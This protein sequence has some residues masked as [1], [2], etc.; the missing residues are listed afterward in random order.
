MN[1]GF[2]YAVAV[3]SNHIR[4]AKNA[5]LKAFEVSS[6][7]MNNARSRGKKVYRKIKVVN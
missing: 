5:D 2:W 3:V 6:P 7:L 1:L 4:L